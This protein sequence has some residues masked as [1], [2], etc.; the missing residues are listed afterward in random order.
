MTTIATETTSIRQKQTSPEGAEDTLPFATP[1]G[2][3][4]RQDQ[5]YLGATSIVGSLGSTLNLLKSESI[6]YQDQQEIPV[7]RKV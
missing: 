1:V 7:H 6:L 5:H 4:D 3:S 2:I